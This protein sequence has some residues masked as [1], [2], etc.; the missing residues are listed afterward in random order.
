ME[1]RLHAPSAEGLRKLANTVAGFASMKCNS[2]K[3]HRIPHVHNT[4]T[5][6]PMKARKIL[7]TSKAAQKAYDI[8]CQ[9]SFLSNILTPLS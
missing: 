6:T 5:S 9:F 3:G 2:E 8:S 4:L 7:F 1:N